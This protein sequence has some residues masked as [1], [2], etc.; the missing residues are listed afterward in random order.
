MLLPQ[1]V[2]LTT[3]DAEMVD[4]RAAKRKHADMESINSSSIV[5]WK[6]VGDNN[7]MYID[8]VASIVCI[9]G[10]NSLDE[11]PDIVDDLVSIEIEMVPPNGPQYQSNMHTG[12]ESI[13]MS[14]NINEFMSIEVS[15]GEEAAK[16]IVMEVESPRVEKRMRANNQLLSSSIKD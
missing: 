5:V 14:I 13:S 2:T 11:D 8:G 6:Q 3:L 1:N 4:P 7:E 16:A 10:F 15:T 9:H 12:E